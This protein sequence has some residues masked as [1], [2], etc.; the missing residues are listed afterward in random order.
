MELVD[1][2]YQLK[3]IKGENLKEK[4]IKEN[5]SCIFLI[6]SYSSKQYVFELD[7]LCNVLYNEITEKE[8]QKTFT[9][10]VRVFFLAKINMCAIIEI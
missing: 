4:E 5:E 6:L 10:I 2:E 1:D 9:V 3:T 7:F 8:I